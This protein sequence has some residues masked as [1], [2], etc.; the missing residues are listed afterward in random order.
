MAAEIVI[1]FTLNDFSFGDASVEITN[2]FA[3]RKKEVGAAR[4]ARRFGAEEGF[5]L[6]NRTSVLLIDALINKIPYAKFSR[7]ERQKYTSLSG[8]FRDFSFTVSSS[9]T[10]LRTE[11]LRLFKKITRKRR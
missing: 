5:I 1:K 3:A 7:P 2:P 4:F 10:R 6:P 11:F 9:T 8:T